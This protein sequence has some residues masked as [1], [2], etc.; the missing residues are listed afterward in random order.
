MLDIDDAILA[1]TTIEPSTIATGQGEAGP[2]TQTLKVR[3]NGPEAVTY[4]LSH[5]NAVST[6]GVITPSF[7]TATP[8]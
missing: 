8:Q 1:T 4:D 6:G 7:Y 3:N 5:V 2:Y